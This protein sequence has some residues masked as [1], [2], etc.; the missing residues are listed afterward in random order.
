MLI[1]T[2]EIDP[3]ALKEL[4]SPL[5]KQLVGCMHAHNELTFLN[6]LLLF[7]MN[8]TAKGALYDQGKDAQM[9]CLM[10][11][12]AGKLFE[13]WKMLIERDSVQGMQVSESYNTSLSW[14]S[15]YFGQSKG[16]LKQCP[17]KF[18]RNKTA[19]HYDNLD[20][21]QAVGELHAGENAIH[22]NDGH[23]VNQLYFLGSAVVFRSVFAAIAQEFDPTPGRDYTE[24][25]RV[26]FEMVIRD[27]TDAN[28][29]THQ[30]LYAITAAILEQIPGKPLSGRRLLTEVV[31]APAPELIGL[32]PWVTMIP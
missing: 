26:G 21:E 11:L 22:L 5:R 32:P 13:T 10:Q 19:F 12:L 8:D 6:R 14:L 2:I 31:G 20:F 18:I 7:S 30:L 23:P 9:W 3:K 15:S 25:V 29:H 27:I 17:I 16:A 28:F 4:P 24:K 1:A